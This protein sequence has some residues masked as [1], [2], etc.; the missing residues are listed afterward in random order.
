MTQHLTD[1][2]MSAALLADSALLVDDDA[3]LATHLSSCGDCRNDLQR[4]RAVLG[5]VRAQSLAIAERP[6]GFWRKQRAAIASR[7]SAG[8]ELE[9]R[10]LAWVASFAVIALVAAFLTQS[11][12]SIQ[13]QSKRPAES[14]G[15]YS[16]SDPDHDL[17]L[18][19][20]RSVRREVPRAL[21]PASL[22]AQ[23]LHT[24]AGRKSDR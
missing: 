24:A 14:I 19:I 11:A 17:L 18:D 2:Q 3:S 7:I 20:Q 8:H 9:T 10:P 6:Q 4:M 13:I 16:P 21:E 15:T 23:E 5:G 22:I 12:P 1:E